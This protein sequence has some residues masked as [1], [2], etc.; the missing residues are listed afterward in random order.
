MARSSKRK[1]V[2]PTRGNASSSAGR[3]RRA[4]QIF[5]QGVNPAPPTPPFTIRRPPQRDAHD[6]GTPSQLVTDAH[7]ADILGEDKNEDESVD[8]AA[9]DDDEP[10]QNVLEVVTGAEDSPG[11]AA[12]AAAAA[13]PARST[14]R[15]VTEELE[16]LVEPRL[17]FRWR[18]CWGTMERG[19]IATVLA[20]H[21][22]HAGIRA[23]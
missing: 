11:V 20:Q 19:A 13:S 18:A 3:Q 10:V 14:Q 4:P 2:D 5:E 23:T 9:D 22:S 8:A 7:A 17:H 6:R 1:N 12:A 16:A 15:G 21:P